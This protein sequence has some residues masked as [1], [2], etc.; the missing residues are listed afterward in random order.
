MVVETALSA[1]FRPLLPHIH[2]ESDGLDAGLCGANV[3]RNSNGRG[4]LHESSLR[5]AD[6]VPNVCDGAARSDRSRHTQSR[7]SAAPQ[8]VVLP[9]Q[10][11]ERRSY[12]SRAPRQGPPFP[13]PT[14]SP[15]R[16]AK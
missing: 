6:S 1:P 16:L 3:A 9:E 7:A 10:D 12:I 5:Q 14:L 8:A 13:P 2:K 11:A 4:A 15:P